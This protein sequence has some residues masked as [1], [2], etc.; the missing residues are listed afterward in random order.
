MSA[1]S[2]EPVHW[3]HIWAGDRWHGSAWHRPAV[4][5]FGTLAGAQ[6]P[7]EVYVGVVGDLSE[8]AGVLRFLAEA[9]PG[10]KAVVQADEGYEQVTI[11]AMHI[12]SKTVP[13][14]TPV[15]YAHTKGALNDS[16]P[17]ALWRRAMDELTAGCWYDRVADLREYDAVGLH[18][19]THEQF[20]EYI[21]PRKPMFGGNF[22]WARAGYLAGLEPV[23]GTPERPPVNRWEA[24]GWLGQGF[25]K[26]RDLRPG[27]PDYRIAVP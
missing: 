25:P 17:N 2:P 1:S 13:D 22:W 11:D 12:W 26:I 16:L 19:L 14:G 9:W 20:P 5:H 8:R 7:G 24:E 15:Y 23:T 27:W 18:W 21:N 3:Y 6:F 10:A 4:E